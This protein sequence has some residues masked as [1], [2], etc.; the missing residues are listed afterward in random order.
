MADDSSYNADMDN[1]PKT[2]RWDDAGCVSVTGL[3]PSDFL[4][5]YLTCDLTRLQD[6]D[7]LPMALCNLKGRVIVSGWVKTNS[8]GSIDLIV[9][10]SLTHRLV[11][12][13]TPYARFSR[14]ELSIKPT[15][16][17]VER[18]AGAG[19]AGHFHLCD[20]PAEPA[21]DLSEHINRA[22]IENRFAWVTEANSEKFL[23]Q[24]LDLHN[25]NAVDFDK[26]CYLGQEIVARAQ[27]RGQVKR[28]L[29]AFTYAGDRP[30]PGSENENGKIVIAVTASGEF[31]PGIGLAVG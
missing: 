19:I 31:G 2:G 29:V 22:L 28:G 18:L 5:G 20:P 3:N 25:R 27:F 14:C 23:P 26:G 9:H 21:P 15:T 6:E 8:D 24:V 13:L 30:S 17:C 10:R 11:D 7:T 1:I 4:Q 12:V 16:L